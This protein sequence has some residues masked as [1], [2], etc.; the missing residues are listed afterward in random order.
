MKQTATSPT[1]PRAADQDGAPPAPVPR[2]HLESWQHWMIFAVVLV[3]L[4]EARGILGPFLIAGITAY[5]FTGAVT[6]VQ[7]RL[8]WPRVLVA[9][10]LYLLVLVAIGGLI[11]FGARALINQT[12]E[13]SSQGPSLVESA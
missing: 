1:A 9:A 12:V 4:Y 5:I 3:F 6:A 7:E 10:L 8:R 11:Y 13:L 2:I